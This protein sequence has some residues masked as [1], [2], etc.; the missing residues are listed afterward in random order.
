MDEYKK[1]TVLFLSLHNAVRS[2]IAEGLLRHFRG[3]KFES[4]SAGVQASA[5]TP[6]TVKVMGEIEIDI[7]GFQSK[8]V[9]IYADRTFDYVISLYDAA[10]EECP[11]F[12]NAQTK[13]KWD[14]PDPSKVSRSEELDLAAYRTL[15]DGILEKIRSELLATI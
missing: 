12:P 2:Q 13:L 15:R 10:T 14:F 5:I 11:D 9:D 4:L 3:D 7:S 1:K 6:L 8:S